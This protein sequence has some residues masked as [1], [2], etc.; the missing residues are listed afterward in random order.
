MGDQSA[1]DVAALIREHGPTEER[2]TAFLRA[3]GTSADKI[4]LL[5]QLIDQDASLLT[6]PQLLQCFCQRPQLDIIVFLLQR[7]AHVTLNT[8]FGEG[9]PLARAVN[10]GA[11]SDTLRAMLTWGAMPPHSPPH[12]PGVRANAE[13][14]YAYAMY[15]RVDLEQVMTSVI[16]S[17]F[18]S[19]AAAARLL[20]GLA[21]PTHPSP[22]APQPLQSPSATPSTPT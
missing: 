8:H 4:R 2:I 11:T 3:P 10:N 12:S 19:V 9:S 7:G 13:L 18:E 14:R 21:S 17:A 20:E 1:A 5:A 22:G 6:T 15:I 16:H